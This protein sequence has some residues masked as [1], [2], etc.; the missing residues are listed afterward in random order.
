MPAPK[1]TDGTRKA[2]LVAI[3][4]GNSQ[5]NAAALVGLRGETL[6][7]WLKEGRDAESGD[8]HNFAKAVAKAKIRGEQA[9]IEHI[10]DTATAGLS[11]EETREEVSDNGNK[12]TV[13]TKRVVDWRAAAWLLERRDP[14]HWGAAAKVE[15]DDGHSDT[16]P[17]TDSGLRALRARQYIADDAEDS[18]EG[19]GAHE[20]GSGNGTGP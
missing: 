14:Q 20:N 11:H 5:K 10:R 4:K 9:L 12:T 15:D 17:A 2:I 6:S 8:F 1:F 7:R 18:E 3:E 16:G 19:G 13:I